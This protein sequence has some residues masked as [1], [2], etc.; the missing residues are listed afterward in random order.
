MSGGGVKTC[1]VNTG[2][3]SSYV[4]SVVENHY[5]RRKYAQVTTV[6]W[7]SFCFFTHNDRCHVYTGQLRAH[8]RKQCVD[9]ASHRDVVLKNHPMKKLLAYKIAFI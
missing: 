4:I 7:L 8:M 1:V 5:R 2:V 9:V 3:M 6:D